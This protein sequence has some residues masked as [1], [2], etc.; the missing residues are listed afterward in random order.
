MQIRGSFIILIL[1]LIFTLT[2]AAANPIQHIYENFQSEPAEFLFNSFIV[3]FLLVAG[4]ILA[5]IILM[6]RIWCIYLFHRFDNRT[7]D[8][9]RG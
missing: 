6:V 5:G 1:S 7:H 9:R 3:L 4:G 2:F 8:T